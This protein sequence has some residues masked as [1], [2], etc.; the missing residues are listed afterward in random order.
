M[1]AKVL[2]QRPK[3]SNLNVLTG[4]RASQAQAD[5]E[6]EKQF[7]VPKYKHICT[8]KHKDVNI[9]THKHRYKHCDYLSSMVAVVLARRLRKADLNVSM[10]KSTN[11]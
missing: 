10:R 6:E 3:K 9:N 4:S 8:H 1:E 2:A 7:I 5:S 11:T